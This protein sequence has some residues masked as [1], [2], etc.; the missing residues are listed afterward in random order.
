MSQEQ[1]ANAIGCT[2]MNVSHKELGRRK[3]SLIELEKWANAL[4]YE[5][6]ISL[7]PLK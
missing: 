3:I 4:G 2:F 6:A 1:I 5:V 7:I